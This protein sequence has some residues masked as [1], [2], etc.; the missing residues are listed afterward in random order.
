MYEY[1][2][3][4]FTNP[5]A[6]AKVE[7]TANTMAREGWRLAM[8]YTP[9]SHVATFVFERVLDP[10]YDASVEDEDPIVADM[11]EGRR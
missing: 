1:R 8:I 9:A 10:V 7:A 2:V 4:D 6:A 5:L 3:E 11:L